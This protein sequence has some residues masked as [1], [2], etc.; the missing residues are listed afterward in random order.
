MAERVSKRRVRGH[1]DGTARSH[2]WQIL[3]ATKGAAQSFKIA[4][5]VCVRA[6]RPQQLQMMVDRASN[7]RQPGLA[8]GI[9]LSEI[10]HG[11]AELMSS[12]LPLS[13]VAQECVPQQLN[14]WL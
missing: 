8:A 4:V 13:S 11:L 7:K 9:A 14:Q 5:L 2:F 1:A 3:A 6:R 10:W 12:D